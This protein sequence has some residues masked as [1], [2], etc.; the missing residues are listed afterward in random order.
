MIEKI[1]KTEIWQELSTNPKF[2]TKFEDCIR[3]YLY[4]NTINDLIFE[5]HDNKLTILHTSRV[6]NRDLDCQYKSFEETEFYLDSDNSLIVN[7]LTGKLESRY[8]YDFK[9][10][11][12]GVINTHYSCQVFNNEG[13]ELN[14]QSYGDKY[15]LDTNE[16]S[17][18]K[19]DLR[20][21][22]EGPYNPKIALLANLTGVYPHPRVIGKSSR[23]VRQIRSENDL[24]TIE[25]SRCSF[26][27]ETGMV[28]NPREELYF[29][30]FFTSVSRNTPEL[31]HIIN[32]FPF[33]V[34]TEDKQIKIDND[35][36]KLGLTEENY[37]D[38]SKDR[39]LRELK[40][41]KN[42]FKDLDII[43]QYDLMIKKV[44][45]ELSLA[46]RIH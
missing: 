3:K 38:V 5:I 18:F 41:E 22:V 28:Q 16:F 14:Y 30:L 26:D 17:A 32:G 24:G 13:I 15:H 21:I 25:V 34:I 31:I 20:T 45:E 4:N 42:N 35:Y 39:F 43:A 7:E 33:A 29:N 19:D 1:K 37:K 44:E 11:P 9:N 46:K 40:S 27:K 12:G 2:V 36:I 23:Y 10:T 6:I 8:G